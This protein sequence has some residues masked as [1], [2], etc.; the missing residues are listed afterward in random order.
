MLHSNTCAIIRVR[1]AYI[2]PMFSQVVFNILLFSC[3]LNNVCSLCTKEMIYMC[4]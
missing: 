1:G 4:I 3:Y 2:Y